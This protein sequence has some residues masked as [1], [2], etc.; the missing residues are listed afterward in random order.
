MNSNPANPTRGSFHEH[1]RTE[2]ER[3]YIFFLSR[4][5]PGA[6][7]FL[8]E[9]PSLWVCAFVRGSARTI[10]QSPNVHPPSKKKGRKFTGRWHEKMGR[11]GLNC[12]AANATLHEQAGWKYIPFLPF[13]NHPSPLVPAPQPSCTSVIPPCPS[14][15]LPFFRVLFLPSSTKLILPTPPR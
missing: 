5:V 10:V 15:G 2:I 11:K 3:V 4:P 9:Q 8:T 13:R 6:K 14:D 7:H 1:G 12:D